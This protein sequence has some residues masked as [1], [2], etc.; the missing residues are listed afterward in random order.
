MRRKITKLLEN[1]K[2]NPGKKPLLIKGARQVGKT[3]IINEFAKANYR[4]DRIIRINFEERPQ[5]REVFDSSLDAETIL[6][7]LS[8]RPE[9]KDIDFQVDV[10]HPLFLFLDEIQKCPKAITSLK[11]LSEAKSYLHVVGSGSL[12]GVQLGKKDGSSFPVGYVEQATLFP[13]DFEEFMWAFGYSEQYIENL[14]ALAYKPNVGSLIEDS[15]HE[16]LMGLFRKFVV[17]GGMP[18]A[19]KSYVETKT[20]KECRAIQR[21]L[22]EA[23][24]VD[25][26]KYVEGAT[27]KVRVA[28]VFKA[29]PKQLTLTSHKFKLATIEKNAKSREYGDPLNWLIS[30]GLVI[31]CENV[32]RIEEP[33]ESFSDSSDFKLYYFDSGLLLSQLS[34]DDFY[35]VL[36]GTQNIDVGGVYENAVAAILHRYHGDGSP[37]HYHH[38]GD[39]LEIDFVDRYRR[40]FLLIEV[41]SGENLKSASLNKALEGSDGHIDGLKVSRKRVMEDGK[42]KN[43]PFYLFALMFANNLYISSVD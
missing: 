31:K 34:D 41:K 29:I 27:N 28:S 24:E 6:D 20:F 22:V 17:I 9:F 19:V 39:D 36:N 32:K 35:A 38:Q 13:L 30:S 10:G 15:V 11:F 1:W 14:K 40:A 8:L 33:L 23:Y 25:I 5:M 42:E 43:L 4:S 16:E 37:L 21:Q 2:N 7:R 26:Q 3:F 12:L 18:A